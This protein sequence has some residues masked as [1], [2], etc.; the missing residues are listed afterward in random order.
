MSERETNLKFVIPWRPNG[1][2]WRKRAQQWQVRQFERLG[3]PYAIAPDPVENGPF[4]VSRS[5]N[6]YLLNNK[7]DFIAFGADHVPSIEVF[8]RTQEQLKTVPYYHPYSRTWDLSEDSTLAVLN[9]SM[10]AVLSNR[11]L[12]YAG[13]VDFCTGLVAMR[14]ETWQA[15]PY[16]NNFKG[17]GY[18]DTAQREAMRTLFGSR[19][20]G[21]ETLIGLYHEKGSVRNPYTVANRD[22]FM[23]EYRPRFGKRDEMEALMVEV[24]KSVDKF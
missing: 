23:N 11:R 24:R 6:H 10:E 22:R 21:K 15:V 9:G 8:R 16:D 20:A 19:A 13:K 1:D 17:W 12:T 14:Y 7:H 18:E 3:L 5:M 4:S 2:K